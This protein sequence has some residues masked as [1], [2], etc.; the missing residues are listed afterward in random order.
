[1]GPL[2]E[3]LLTFPALVAVTYPG[4]HTQMVVNLPEA[5]PTLLT[6]AGLFPGVSALVDIQVGALAEALPTF[7]TFEGPLPR[8]DPLVTDQVG[9]PAEVL[10]TFLTHIGLFPRAI[11]LVLV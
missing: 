8:V 4:Y 11:Y 6:L 1:M 2:V 7:G 5:L 3:A 9:S 10:P